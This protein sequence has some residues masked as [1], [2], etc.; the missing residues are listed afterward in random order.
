LP[1]ESLRKNGDGPKEALHTTVVTG[2]SAA[3]DPQSLIVLYRSHLGSCGNLFESILDSRDAERTDLVLQGDLSTSN[4]VTAEDL[5][6]RLNI[7]F[8]GCSAHARRP[9]ALY[10]DQDPV[11]CGAMLH[12]FTGLA[13]HE[14]QLDEFGRNPQNV[15]A[16]RG[17]E[18]RELWNDILQ[19]AKKMANWWSKAT[20]LGAAARYIIN[21]FEELTAYLDD[22]R[23]EPSN[24]LRE[25]MLR[26]E[27][28]IEGSSMFRKTLE[29][30]F[31]LDVVRTILQT[32]VVAGAPPHEYLVA[33]LR[34]SE[35]E[36][37]QHPDRF[38]PRAWAAANAN[39]TPPPASPATT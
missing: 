7:R 13:I 9:F 10:Q 4:L 37:A 26:T 18:S 28:L 19:L 15:L 31:V 34:T 32:A 22:P 20:N 8:I 14:D 30:R 16:V 6:A 39:A 21:H 33:V 38:T 3:D 24:T 25:R 12:L 23:L 1:F 5:L 11:R 36:V 27:K 2:R 29:G 17:A 35:D